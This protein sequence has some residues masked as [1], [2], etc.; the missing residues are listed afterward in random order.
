MESCKQQMSVGVGESNF[1]VCQ[2]TGYISL[3]KQNMVLYA[4]FLGD[5]IKVNFYSESEIETC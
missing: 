1:N 2:Q 4:T 3:M 5:L